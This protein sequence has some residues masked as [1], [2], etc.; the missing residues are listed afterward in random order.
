[1]RITEHRQ[2]DTSPL[3][4]HIILTPEEL[5]VLR[6]DKDGE[7]VEVFKK[8]LNQEIEKRDEIDE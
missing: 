8:I 1:M 5:K 6:S 3:R 7:V 4:Y 2:S